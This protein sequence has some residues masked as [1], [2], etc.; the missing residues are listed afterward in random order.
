MSF[1]SSS[2]TLNIDPYMMDHWSMSLSQK[3]KKNTLERLMTSDLLSDPVCISVLTLR[4]KIWA[5]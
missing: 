1:F 3:K 5:T 4:A 2:L